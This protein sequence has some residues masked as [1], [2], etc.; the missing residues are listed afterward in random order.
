M[1]ALVTINGVDL[2]A[3]STYSGTTATI[4]DSARNAKG[5]TVGAVIRNDVAKVEMTWKFIRPDDWAKMIRLFSPAYGGSFYNDVTFYSDI[6]NDWETRR[7][8]VSDRTNG[9]V[10]M[11]NQEDGSIKGYLGARLALIEV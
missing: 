9:G 8:Y 6:A 2:P 7:M 1:R 11:R 5:V 10:F 3:P 4:V